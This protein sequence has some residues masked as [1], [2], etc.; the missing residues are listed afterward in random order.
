MVFCD[1]SRLFYC[2]SLTWTQSRK[3]VNDLCVFMCVFTFVHTARAEAISMLAHIRLMTV[4][5][6]LVCVITKSSGGLS[7]L[8]SSTSAFCA[9]VLAFP[10]DSHI[11][12]SGCYIL[13]CGSYIHCNGCYILGCLSY[14]RYRGSHTACCCS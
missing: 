3:T 4:G 5:G 7:Y 9:V 12:Y 11:Q 14:I 8:S 2:E 10:A 6:L 13:T 1:T